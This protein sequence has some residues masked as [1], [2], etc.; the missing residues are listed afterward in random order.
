MRVTPIALCSVSTL[1]FC[2]LPQPTIANP[3]AAP[4]LPAVAVPIEP[5]DRAP[6]ASALAGPETIAPDWVEFA[7][8]QIQPVP[9]VN[10]LAIEQVRET[11]GQPDREQVEPIQP[12]APAI[13][14]QANPDLMPPDTPSAPDITRPE[15]ENPEP[16]NPDDVKNELGEIRILPSPKVPQPAPPR[17][18]TVQ[19]FLGSSVFSSSNVTL[20]ESLELGDTVFIN[21]ATLLATPKLGPTTR[22]IA[23]ASGGLVRFANEGDFNYNRLDFRVGIQ[24]R[25]APGMYAQLG[26]ENDQLYRSNN[27]DRLLRSNAVDLL[28]GRQDQIGKQLRLD[29][30]YNLNARFADPDQQNRVAHRLGAR[31]RYDI[32]ANVQAALDYR[33]TFKDFTQVDRFDT[34]HQVSAIATYTINR[35]LFLSGSVSY[36]FGRSSDPDI[37]LGNFSAG[38]SLGWNIPLF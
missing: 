34:E 13:A 30:Y 25:L 6:T 1:A 28:V 36:L 20:L 29:T 38:I 8:P 21:S 27:G 14:V 10:E 12:V 24:Q 35:N 17:Q 37:N 18:P 11:T 2:H 3:I 31:L 26:W 23:A 19:L 9:A 32:S 16:L 4:D 7:A 15:T 33:L 22:L 5:I